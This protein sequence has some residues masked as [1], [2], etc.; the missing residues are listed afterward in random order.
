MAGFLSRVD[1][2]D[3]ADNAY[4][5]RFDG[6]G[7]VCFRHVGA[8]ADAAASDPVAADRDSGIASRGAEPLTDR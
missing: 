1:E 3:G 4:V 5:L 7:Q 2:A 6:N 8:V